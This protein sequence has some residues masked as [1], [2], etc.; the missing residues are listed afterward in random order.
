MS[1]PGGSAVKNLPAMQEP[2]ET[3]VQ[4]LGWEDPLEEGMA[5]HSR[6]LA[7][8]ED[9]GSLQSIESHGL[10]HNWSSLVCMQTL[11]I[12]PFSLF[13]LCL[14][15]FGELL[16][17]SKWFFIVGGVGS[18]LHLQVFIC[19]FMFALTWSCNTGITPVWEGEVEWAELNC[20]FQN[21]REV[22]FF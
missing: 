4:S 2:Q 13:G 19:E 21:F 1:F 8:T 9:P 12:I 15:S 6:I 20:Y 7:W 10:R 22:F 17:W 11:L 3:Q 14:S 5:T 18:C 16:R